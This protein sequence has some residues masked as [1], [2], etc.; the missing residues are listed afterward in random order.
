MIFSSLFFLF[1]FL[2][3]TLL[4]YFIP[5]RKCKNFVILVCSLIFYAWGEPIYIFLM[6]FS[7]VFNYVMGIDID[8]NRDNPAVAKKNFIFAVVV[9]LAILG[10]FKYYGFFIE[11]LNSILPFH[12]RV[13]AIAMWMS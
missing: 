8:N 9:N 1:V 5:P 2:P 13:A 3:A 6:V 7:I 12:V 11:N 10:F 4:L